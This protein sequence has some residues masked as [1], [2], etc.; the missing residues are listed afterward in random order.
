MKK[1]LKRLLS[2]LFPTNLS[3]GRP[4]ASYPV[5]KRKD[6]PVNS[7]S[8]LQNLDAYPPRFDEPF[9]LTQSN[10]FRRGTPERQLWNYDHRREAIREWMEAGFEAC[11]DWNDA[12]IEEGALSF[13]AQRDPQPLAYPDSPWPKGTD[14]RRAW[15]IGWNEACRE[16]YLDEER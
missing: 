6:V 4:G 1:L 11:C 14:E 7:R 8:Q 13:I 9:Q 2:A 10:P 5:A 12:M 3:A 16:L 15:I